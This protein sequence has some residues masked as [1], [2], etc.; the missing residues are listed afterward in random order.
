MAKSADQ[1][2][3]PDPMQM[4]REWVDQAERQWNSAL[5]EL[6]GTEEF[7]QASGRMMEIFMAMQVSM[8]DATQKYFSALNLPTRNDLMALGERLSSIEAHLSRIDEKLGS[9]RPSE[10]ARRAAARPKPKRTRKAPSK[11]A[12]TKAAAAKK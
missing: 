2:A 3:L 11:A 9:M 10:P 1:R 6:M 7:G 5:N 12:A 8:N 4:W